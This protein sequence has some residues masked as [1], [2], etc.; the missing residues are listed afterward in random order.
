[1]ER[2]PN[3][4]TKIFFGAPQAP[5]PGGAAPA[6]PMGVGATAH[7]VSTHVDGRKYYN[8]R[9]SCLYWSWYIESNIRNTPAA[10][11]ERI[12]VHVHVHFNRYRDSKKEIQP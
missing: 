6:P 11:Y 1:M 10:S 9:G 3:A 12:W 5:E 7:Q 2:D 8:T 4:R